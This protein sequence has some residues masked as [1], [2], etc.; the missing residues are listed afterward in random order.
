MQFHWRSNKQ[1]TTAQSSTT[2]ELVAMSECMKDVNLRMWIAEEIGHQIDWPVKIKVD[3]KAAV[4][5]QNNMAPDSKLKGIFDMRLGWLQELH[6][7]NKFKAVKIA[8]DKNLADELTKPLA[9]VVKKKLAKVHRENYQR[10][11][12]P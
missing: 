2:A 8:T 10:V 9:Q 11:V 4:S 7:K 5:F 6:D 1:T 3:N 12:A